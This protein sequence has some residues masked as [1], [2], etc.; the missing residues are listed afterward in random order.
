[1]SRSL[2]TIIEEAGVSSLEDDQ[3]NHVP[4]GRSPITESKINEVT[5]RDPALSRT[6]RV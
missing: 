4:L 2:N 5:R 1:M 6:L 3:E